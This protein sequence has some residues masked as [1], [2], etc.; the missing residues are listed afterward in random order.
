MRA[1]TGRHAVP[2]PGWA[3]DGV[4]VGGACMTCSVG[5]RAQAQRIA[6]SCASRAFD[7][8]EP[9]DDDVLYRR[10]G[11]PATD[12]PGGS[13]VASP[14]LRS[15][16]RSASRQTRPRRARMRARRGAHR[17]QAESVWFDRGRPARA[18]RNARG[19]RLT[20]ARAFSTTSGGST[21]MA[22]VAIAG[23]R[24]ARAMR[25][26]A[27]RR[28]LGAAPL[29]RLSLRA[30]ELV[31]MAAGGWVR[32]DHGE[33]R[34]RRCRK[35]SESRAALKRLRGRAQRVVRGGKHGMA[36]TLPERPELR[37]LAA[38]RGG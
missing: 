14:T 7:E 24:D 1:R 16:P 38:Q 27:D 20:G 25:E 35:S 3:H 8:A 32:V 28:C 26:L 2:S 10:H 31:A 12:T 23:G 11:S 4:A 9:R 34:R 29:A 36:R 19:L 5:L 37:R 17:A 30:R 33:E 18:C 6:R 22:R 15:M 21:S 13:A